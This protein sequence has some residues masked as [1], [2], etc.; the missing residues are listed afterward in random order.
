MEPNI[1][2]G[3]QIASSPQFRKRQT[4]IFKK[5]SNLLEEEVE[6]SASPPSEAPTDPEIIQPAIG[7]KNDDYGFL[8]NF[9]ESFDQHQQLIFGLE[10]DEDESPKS[11]KFPSLTIVEKSITL[12]I[13]GDCPPAA[14]ILDP[15]LRQ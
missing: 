5:L 14:T 1:E 9:I 11:E 7:K 10:E 13:V 12:E 2:D 15:A 3:D 8:G 6:E 4:Q